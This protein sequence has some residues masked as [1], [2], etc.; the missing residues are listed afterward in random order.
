MSFSSINSNNRSVDELKEKSA[1]FDPEVFGGEL[2]DL[3][4]SH[5]LSPPVYP[6]K[7]QHPRVM[8]WQLPYLLMP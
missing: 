4:V 5:F 2:G 8:I 3:F 7:G 6:K 1:S